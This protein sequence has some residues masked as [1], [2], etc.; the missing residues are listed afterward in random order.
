MLDVFLIEGASNYDYLINIGTL[1]LSNY[2]K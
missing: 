2:P 1:I